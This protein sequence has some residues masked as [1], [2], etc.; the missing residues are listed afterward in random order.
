MESRSDLF[1]SP[2]WADWLVRN[3]DLVAPGESEER[4]AFDAEVA[5]LAEE[6]EAIARDL[7][8]PTISAPAMIDGSG[9]NEFLLIRGSSKTPGPEVP[10]RFLEAIAGDTPLSPST[11]GSGRLELARQLTSP[12]NPFASRVI[13]NRIWH[14]LFG[15]GIVA[16]T[17]NF[18]VL[19]EP[20]TN[21]ELLDHLADRFLRDGGSIKHLIKAIVLT[22]A[23]QMS[24]RPDP[25]A[26]RQD[27][28]NK[29]VH[30][31]AI[32]R[33]E[34]ESI[35]DALLAVSGTTR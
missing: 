4:R 12:T 20:P 9:V 25:E 32:R 3:I 28:D 22:R 27:P 2:R 30:R 1:P 24:S 10:R 11:V 33:L 15:R 18:G 29:L 17:D 34:A 35:R 19:G 8:T 14:H 13:V 21:P 5:K 23:Y 26:D 7:A 31:M 6:Q 16:S